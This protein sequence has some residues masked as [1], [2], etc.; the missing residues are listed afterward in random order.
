[1]VER[2]TRP[3]PRMRPTREHNWGED[4]SREKTRREKRWHCWWNSPQ[5]VFYVY[6]LWGYKVLVCSCTM[7]TVLWRALSLPRLVHLHQ[8]SL[9]SSHPFWL[10]SWF[11]LRRRRRRCR[12]LL[13]H[14]K[15]EISFIAVRLMSRGKDIAWFINDIV[16][17]VVENQR[18]LLIT[19][20]TT[21]S[22]T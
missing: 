8:A 20:A 17:H 9:G 19:L 4:E 3:R 13:S 7:V 11:F 22:S 18:V 16:A 15:W 1:M 21:C 14:D 2:K 12:S 5:N 10:D 6:M